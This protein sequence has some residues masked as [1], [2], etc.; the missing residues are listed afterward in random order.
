MCVSTAMV[1]SPKATFST[2]L[3]VLRPTPGKASS[4][5]GR[6]GPGRRAFPPVRGRAARRCWLSSATG[7]W[8]GCGAQRRRRRGRPSRLRVGRD[9]EQADGGRLTD[10]SVAWADS[11]TAT[12]RVNGSVK[13]SSVSG[14]GLW[15]ASASMKA[16]TSA[17]VIGFVLR[18]LGVAAGMTVRFSAAFRISS[19]VVSQRAK[20]PPSGT[21]LRVGDQVLADFDL[22]MRQA[23]LVAVGGDAVVAVFG[24]RI[25]RVVADDEVGF[26]AQQVQQ[27]AGESRVLVVQQADLHGAAFAFEGRGETVHRDQHGAAAGRG[28]PAGR[29]CGRGRG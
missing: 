27:D 13:V 4:A 3:A 20:R 24:E 29:R 6:R 10:R 9:G 21:G 23:A 25:G 1:L 26:P 7:R 18:G 16:R 11:T 8:S 14:A 17:L 28:R 2:T 19:A 12:S 15:A 5:A 22:D